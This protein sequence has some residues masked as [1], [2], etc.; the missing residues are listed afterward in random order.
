MSLKTGFWASRLEFGPRDWDLSWG[1]TEE[2]EEVEE[3]E[4]EKEKIPFGVAALLT[5]QLQAQTT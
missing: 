3:K 4:E 1:G 5:L 2:E